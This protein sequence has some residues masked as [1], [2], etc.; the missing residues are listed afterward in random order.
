VYK[1]FVIKPGQKRRLRRPGHR[2][3]NNIKMDH[4]EVGCEVQGWIQRVQNWVQ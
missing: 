2:R 3:E 4:K 1:I